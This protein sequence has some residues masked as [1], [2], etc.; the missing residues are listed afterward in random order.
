MVCTVIRNWKWNSIN[1]FICIQI[2]CMFLL[3]THIYVHI[4]TYIMYRII[5][6]TS[7]WEKG[8]QLAYRDINSNSFH[9][10]WLIFWKFLP[11]PAVCI[12]VC[13]HVPHNIDTSSRYVADMFAEMAKL[14][15]LYVYVEYCILI[16]TLN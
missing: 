15:L 1:R 3:N 4:H 8:N 16:L 10:S 5:K 6:L 13:M 9:Y 7:A 11:P 14:S 2:Q 12:C